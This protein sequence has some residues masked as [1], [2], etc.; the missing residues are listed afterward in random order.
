[1][2]RSPNISIEENE[3]IHN[4]IKTVSK[5]DCFIMGN[6]NH[7]HIQ[8]TSLQSTGR[9]DQEFK[10]LVQDFLSQHVLEATRVENVGRKVL[11]MSRYVSH[12]GVVIT[13]DTFYHQSK[14]RTE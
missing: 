4:A 2:Y 10:N 6:C 5:R 1:M 11:I 14:G 3:K 7:G 13:T 8:W 12:C 9:E